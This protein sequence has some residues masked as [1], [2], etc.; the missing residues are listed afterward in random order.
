MLQYLYERSARDDD[1]ELNSNIRNSLLASPLCTG[2]DK[3]R[4]RRVR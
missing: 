4:L 3:E 1:N 2:A